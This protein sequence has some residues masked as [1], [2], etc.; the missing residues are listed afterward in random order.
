MKTIA[1][2]IDE[3]SLV[4]ID[5]LARAS[6]RRRGTRPANRSE[7]VRRAVQELVAREKRREREAKDRR[8]LA[9]HRE[10]IARQAGA[11]VAEQAEP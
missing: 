11:L 1:I 5:Q 9:A 2:S 4:A 10:L 3:E 8:A 7:V 6:G